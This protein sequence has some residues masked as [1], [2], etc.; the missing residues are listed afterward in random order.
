MKVIVKRI[1]FHLP[2]TTTKRGPHDCPKLV[3][4]ARKRAIPIK[5]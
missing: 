3:S 1:R 2:S 5:R 4:R